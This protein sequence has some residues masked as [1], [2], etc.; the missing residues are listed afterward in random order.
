MNQTFQCYIWAREQFKTN[1]FNRKIWLPTSSYE[2]E[3]LGLVYSLELIRFF[4][5]IYK[6]ESE[7]IHQNKSDFTLQSKSRFYYISACLVLKAAFANNVTFKIAIQ[8]LV[9]LHSYSLELNSKFCS[10]F[11]GRFGWHFLFDFFSSKP[12]STRVL[13]YVNIVSHK[14]H[15]SFT[16]V[17]RHNQAFYSE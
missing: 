11:R 14:W 16:L 9:A 17:K 7:T 13:G 15:S 10:C 2:K 3:Q 6:I 4:T 12:Y 1:T 5:A 8:L